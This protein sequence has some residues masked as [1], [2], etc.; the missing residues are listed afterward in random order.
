MPFAFHTYG[1][2]LAASGLGDR[3]AAARYVERARAFAPDF[4][5]WFAPDGGAFPFGRSLT[6]RLA[7][8]SF[9][10]ALALADVDALD[11]PTVRGLALRH[12][13]WWSER[14]ISD[15]DG[16]RVGRLRL[17][18]PPDGASRTTRPA[19]RTGA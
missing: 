7:Q 16:V 14:P 17:R 3:D 10:G 1:L 13:R 9:W 18:Q 12:L 2:V 19:R 6:Y 11:W 15:R 8:G 5:H 4:Q